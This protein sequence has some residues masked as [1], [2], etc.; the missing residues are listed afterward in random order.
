MSTLSSLRDRLRTLLGNTRA[1]QLPRRSAKPRIGSHIVH[2]SAG[3]RMLVQA[4]M[5]DEL[6]IWLMDHGWRVVMH[7]PERR[8]YRELPSSYVT[9]LIDSEVGE[10]NQLLAEAIANAEARATVVTKSFHT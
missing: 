5:S 1:R 10:R 7:R 4:G 2:V 6:W 3:V 9:R 8:Q